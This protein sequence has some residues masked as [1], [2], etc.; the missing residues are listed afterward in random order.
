MKLTAFRTIDRVHLDD[1][2]SV[3]L[4]DPSWKNR[5]P[6]EFSPRLEE[7]F[8]AFD[9]WPDEFEKAM[10]EAGLTSD[11]QLAEALRRSKELDDG[12]VTGLPWFLVRENAAQRIRL[13]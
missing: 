8:D 13:A 11:D 5:F 7:V 3:A 2:L 4:F 1:L 9:V 12:T 6:S 10:L